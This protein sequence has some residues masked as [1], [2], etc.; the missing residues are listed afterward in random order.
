MRALL[1]FIG[2]L[3]AA[4]LATMP[5]SGALAQEPP[6]PP[7]EVVAAWGCVLFGS[8]GTAGAVAA[9]SENLI[10]VLAG[11]VVAPA[12]PAILYIGLAGVVF[13][14]FC[15]LGMQLTPLYLHYYQPGPTDPDETLA[16][17]GEGEG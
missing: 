12:N 6:G 2:V 14:T 15:T 17:A 13:T 10:N 1:R 4:A 8:A 5:L 7:K 11:G 9:N 3:V 16:L